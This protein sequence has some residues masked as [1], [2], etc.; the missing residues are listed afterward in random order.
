MYLR[1]S[2]RAHAES[3]RVT[4]RWAYYT[5]FNQYP[6][7]GRITVYVCQEPE[8]EELIKTLGSVLDSVKGKKPKLKV[9]KLKLKNAEDFPYY[10]N[11]LEELYG[12]IATAE[13]RKYGIQSLPAVVYNDKV[14][15]QGR[16]PTRG[17]IE[18][19]L[20]YEGL[21]ISREVI[22]TRPSLRPASTQAIQPEPASNRLKIEIPLRNLPRVES[23]P[24]RTAG[25]MQPQ[26]TAEVLTPTPA[27]VKR[28]EQPQQLKPAAQ[29]RAETQPRPASESAV[30]QPASL[31]ESPKPAAVKAPPV[32]IEELGV[33]AKHETPKAPL[34]PSVPGKNCN[35]CIFYDKS[36]KRCLLYRAAITDPSNPLCVRRS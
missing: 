16:V 9:V 24:S 32:E 22:P 30:R 10:L 35:S 4:A 28:P 29:V 3:Q 5:L 33:E 1:T 14:V 11:T 34:I 6:V 36:S 23:A 8:H 12:G 26:K 21:K 19:A 20:A 18:E 25:S 31:L 17:E 15:L 2:P 7:G 27:V 13:Y